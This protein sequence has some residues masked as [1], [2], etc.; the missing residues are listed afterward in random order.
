MRRW[1]IPL[2]LSIAC[3]DTYVLPVAG[4][5]NAMP[6]AQA[7]TGS[8]VRIGTMVSIDGSGSFDPDGE[9]VAHRWE[10]VAVPP[11]SAAMLSSSMTSSSSFVADVVGTYFVTLSVQDDAGA[12]AVDQV[13]FQAQPL[14]R[15][16]VTVDAGADTT[17]AWLAR[18]L[19]T[20]S[21]SATDGFTPT[22]MWTMT[23][24][25]FY[26]TATLVN[27]TSLMPGFI[28]DAQG[29]YTL[30]LTASA[31]GETA[32]DSVTVTASTVGQ[33]FGGPVFDEPIAVAY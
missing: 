8:T 30:Q 17:I 1:L 3:R 14:P 23:A 18:G 12:F 6:L 16:Q 10:L 25:P 7:G 28:A 15:T 32:T 33:S 2:V 5:V 11:G 19:I 4:E 26:S 27:A 29:T 24:R 31:G 21:A 9:L 20:G 22:V 13:A